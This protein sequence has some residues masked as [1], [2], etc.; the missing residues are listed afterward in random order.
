[1]L[2][3]KVPMHRTAQDA[4]TWMGDI[5]F[6]AVLEGNSRVKELK[7]HWTACF[8]AGTKGRGRGEQSKGQ[9]EE[10]LP[11]IS[12]PCLGHVQ[13]VLFQTTQTVSCS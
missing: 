13:L 11:V 6:Q 10:G 2:I 1:M 4:A 9:R 12:F 7:K 8:R 3:K 5:L